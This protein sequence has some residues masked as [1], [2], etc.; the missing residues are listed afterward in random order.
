[1]ITITVPATTANLGSGFDTLG[2]ALKVYLQLKLRPT[3]SPSSLIVRGEGAGRLPTGPRNAIRR[4][5]ETVARAEGVVL[6]AVAMEVMSEIPVARG[7]GS[8]AAAIIAGVLAAD[9]LGRLGLSTDAVLAYAA[10]LEGHPDNVTPALVGGLVA[11]CL[12]P[13]QSVLYVK[14]ALPPFIKAVV[15]IPEFELSTARA[16]RV[17]PKKV[18]LRDAVY[19]LQRVAVL[20]AGIGAGCWD[21]LSEGMRDRLHQPYRESLVPGL[22]ESLIIKGLPGLLGVALSGAG[23]T[24]LALARSHCTAIARRLRAEFAHHGIAARALI[25]ES[26]A[27]GA[28]VISRNGG[29]GVRRAR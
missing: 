19:N 8:S 6:P 20:T 21:V 9:R 13:D 3:R 24:L 5:M 28:R 4:A 11:S 18:P 27:R 15:V 10:R 26:D 2:L 22:A 25:L 14:Q 29:F 17:L 7:L 12:R 1:M 23:P 16:R